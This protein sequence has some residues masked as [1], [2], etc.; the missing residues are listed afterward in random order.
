MTARRWFVEWI[1][2][3]GGGQQ[4]NAAVAELSG[5][6]A[7]LLLAYA[8]LLWLPGLAVGALVGL[9]GWSLAALGPLL[10]YGLVTVSG[11]WMSRLGAPWRP[12]T[13]VLVLL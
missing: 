3:H 9:R 1:T 8:V 10:T 12:D 7:G 5:P 6:Q 11:P 4:L 2:A 13:A